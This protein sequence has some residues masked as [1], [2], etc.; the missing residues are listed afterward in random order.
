MAVVAAVAATRRSAALR[1]AA[2]IHEKNK[3]LINQRK[4]KNRS[5]RDYDR[6][7]LAEH[8]A[9]REVARQQLTTWSREHEADVSSMLEGGAELGERL[10]QSPL[11]PGAASLSDEEVLGMC[12]PEQPDRNE[13]A[14][15]DDAFRTLDIR[16][17]GSLERADLLRIMG[18]LVPAL[19]S[20]EVEGWLSYIYDE[21]RV[22]HST[23]LLRQ[24][25]Q[26]LLPALS[27]WAPLVR[28]SAAVR[29][30][31]EARRAGAGKPQR[32]PVCALL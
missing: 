17:S 15:L 24:H 18:D 20:A 19:Q 27:E 6:Q 13:L 21:C 7:L 23:P 1:E 31:A 16:G 26:A 22:E 29:A 25:M 8:E 11:R 5:A 9:R 32:S 28:R 30:T 3:K 2:I 4:E 12:V 10:H 14:Y